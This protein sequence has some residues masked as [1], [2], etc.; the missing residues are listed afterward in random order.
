MLSTGKLIAVPMLGQTSI[1]IRRAPAVGTARGCRR[2]GMSP[3]VI[4]RKHWRGRHNRVRSSFACVCCP[5]AGLL[6]ADRPRRDRATRPRGSTR[7]DPETH[8]D[9]VARELGGDPWLTGRTPC[10]AVVSRYDPNAAY[11]A[12]KAPRGGHSQL[13]GGLDQV[14]S[15]RHVSGAHIGS[16]RPLGSPG[17]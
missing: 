17:R 6:L 9:S 11:L 12:A 16:K 14:A 13:S 4:W 3:G 10:S 7:S 5:R 1:M 8:S 15:P 2:V